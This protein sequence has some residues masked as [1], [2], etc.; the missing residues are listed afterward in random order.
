M[1]SRKTPYFIFY[2]SSATALIFFFTTGSFRY[3]QDCAT[4][5]YVTDGLP[6]CFLS[7]P[8]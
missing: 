3:K 1:D 7:S 2:S 6:D 5:R 4:F 8:Y